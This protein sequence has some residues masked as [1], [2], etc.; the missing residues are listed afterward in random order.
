M[1]RSLACILVAIAALTLHAQTTTATVQGEVRDPTGA[2]ISGATVVVTNEN[3]GTSNQVL[4]NSQGVY[5]IP[6]LQ[7]GQYSLSVK[8]AGFSTYSR[9]NIRLDVQ[10][11]FT[12]DVALNLGNVNTEVAVAG[13]CVFVFF[14]H[15]GE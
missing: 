10:Q 14:D 4:T 7:P 2:A 8:A 1:N 3:N 6:F 15:H 5:V 13:D 12:Q 11:V 9:V